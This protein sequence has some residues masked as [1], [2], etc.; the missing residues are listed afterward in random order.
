MRLE[1]ETILSTKVLKA[2][3]TDQ[4]LFCCFSAVEAVVGCVMSDHCAHVTEEGP[5]EQRAAPPGRSQLR[6][7]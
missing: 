6:V 4:I 2:A 1:N 7:L 3:V 5:G